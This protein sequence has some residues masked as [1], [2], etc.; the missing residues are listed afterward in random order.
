[1]TNTRDTLYR[2]M[3]KQIRTIAAR[4]GGAVPIEGGSASLVEKSGEG[5]TLA[6]GYSVDKTYKTEIID[7]GPARQIINRMPTKAQ[8]RL[9]SLAQ[10]IDKIILI[11]SRIIYTFWDLRPWREKTAAEIADIEEM[12]K[13]QKMRRILRKESNIFARRASN[14]YHRMGLSYMPP[15]HRRSLINGVKKV[16][17]SNIV[18]ERN[19]IWLQ[20]DTARLP[21][22]VNILSLVDDTNI[23]TNVSSSLRHHIEGVYDV[24]RGAWLCIERGRGVRGIPQIVTYEKMMIPF[25]VVPQAA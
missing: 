5:E 17:F 7:E 12:K 3:T 10:I 1:M 23:L 14:A 13:R 4:T 24:E 20:I 2:R 21:Y 25:Y 15:I 16:R 19:A 6:T 9:R 11:I 18:A 22:G 8:R